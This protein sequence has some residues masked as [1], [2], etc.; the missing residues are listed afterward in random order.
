VKPPPRRTKTLRMVS[1]FVPRDAMGCF[2]LFRIGPDSKSI[3]LPGYLKMGWFFLLK[4]IKSAGCYHFP[5]TDYFN[6]FL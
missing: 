6:I 3:C 2:Y 5:L 1:L 4:A